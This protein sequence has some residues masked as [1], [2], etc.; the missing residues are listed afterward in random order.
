V[1]RARI[2]QG[3]G[4]ERAKVEYTARARSAHVAS[5]CLSCRSIAHP[6]TYRSVL[7]AQREG[8]VITLLRPPPGGVAPAAGDAP[9]GAVHSGAASLASFGARAAL[10]GGLAGLAYI[11]T[12]V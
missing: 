12:G 3:A 1:L 11:I 8:V 4:F 6:D 7:P 5:C 2:G 9:Q 10:T